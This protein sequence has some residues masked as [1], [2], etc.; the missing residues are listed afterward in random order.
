MGASDASHRVV[1]AA[2]AGGVTVRIQEFPAGTKT[3]TDAAEAVGCEVAA[4]VKSLV[5]EV[6]G[7][8]VVALIPGDRILDVDLLANAAGG[9]QCRRADLDMVRAATGFVAGGTPPF[10]HRSALRV[11]ADLGLRRHQLLW[12]AGGTPTTV[13]EIALEDLIALA[14]AAWADISVPQSNNPP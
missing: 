6:D 3:A 5:F 2:R 11:F 13:F 4:I 1:A 12:A 7:E 8:P 10:G 9:A 14:E